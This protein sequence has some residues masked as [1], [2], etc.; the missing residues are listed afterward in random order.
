MSSS[1]KYLNMTALVTKAEPEFARL[2]SSIESSVRSAVS[3]SSTNDLLTLKL[4]NSGRRV[5]PTPTPEYVRY[6][7]DYLKGKNSVESAA[8]EEVA[9]GAARSA[10]EEFYTSAGTRKLLSDEIVRQLDNNLKLREALLEEIGSEIKWLNGEISDAIGGPA[11]AAYT[12]RIL[13]TA[14]HAVSSALHTAGGQVV[15]GLA[16]K[17]LATPAVKAALIKAIIVAAHS[18]AF[19][20]IVLIAVKKVGIGVLAQVFLAN[21]AA[22]GGS[23]TIPGL[24]WIVTAAITALLIYDYVTLPDKLANRLAPSLA[25]ALS[26]KD[27]DVHL[28]MMRAFGKMALKGIAEEL[29]KV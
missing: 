21:M 17:A 8:V 6:L 16:A 20:K 27:S 15:A 26:N 29:T 9:L 7:W 4:R 23:A 18:I 5:S 28:A 10:I 13:D 24:G 25:D 1:D 2:R 22:A 11:K 12:Q 19:Q 3:G 14:T